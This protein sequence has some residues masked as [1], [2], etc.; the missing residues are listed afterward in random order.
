MI[1]GIVNEVIK[2]AITPKISREFNLADTTVREDINAFL[3]N[4]IDQFEESLKVSEDKIDEF[5]NEQENNPGPQPADGSP[6]PQAY[7]KET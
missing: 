7:K 1:T 2:I 6:L 5:L 3:R 4:N